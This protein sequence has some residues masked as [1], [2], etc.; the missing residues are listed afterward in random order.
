[1]KKERNETMDQFAAK[2]AEA[3]AE[4]LEDVK[5]VLKE[6]QKNNGLVLTGISFEGNGSISPTIYL[7]NYLEAYE[8]GDIAIEKIVDK[9]IEVYEGGKDVNFAVDNFLNWEKAK[10]RICYKVVGKEANEELLKDVPYTSEEDL[11]KVYYYRLEESDGVDGTASI[12]IHRNHVKAWGVSTAEVKKAAEENTPKILPSTVMGLSKVLA[13][14]MGADLEELGLGEEEE[15]M[16][17]V[18]NT[19]KVFGAAALFYPGVLEKFRDEHGD[20]YIIPSSIHEC[21]LVPQ[22]DGVDA[23]TLRQMVREVNDTQVS[24]EERLSYSVYEYTEDG[25]RIATDVSATGGAA[26]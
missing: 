20:F 2:V 24:V 7:D 1:M 19:T 11:A 16:Y 10:S 3:L 15:K 6:V 14:L 13:D 8:N 17:V 5:P 21:L 12:L 4:R 25:F 18:S 22:K 9:I 23:A 26:V